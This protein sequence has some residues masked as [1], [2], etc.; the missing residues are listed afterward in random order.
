[1]KKPVRGFTLVELLVVMSIIGVL[2][3]I[4]IAQYMN[5]NRRQ[6]LDQATQ[7]LKNNLRFAQSKALAGEKPSNWCASPYHLRGYRLKFT[8]NQNYSIE[9]VCS[10][11][12]TRQVKSISFPGP[13]TKSSG[14]TSVL[15]KVLAQG[16]E[17]STTYFTLNYSGVDSKTVTVT[18]EGKVE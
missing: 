10:D 16:I 17:G 14:S 8:T 9:A 4:G 2:F 11:G 7:E 3:G 13:V 12:G 1:M 15:F 6:I 18:K 5:F